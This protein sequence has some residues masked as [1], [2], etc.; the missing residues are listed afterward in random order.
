MKW[1]RSLSCSVSKT[2]KTTLNTSGALR[3]SLVVLV[4]VSPWRYWEAFCCDVGIVTWCN[5]FTTG[6]FNLISSCNQ[7]QTVNWKAQASSHDVLVRTK[8][9]S[10]GN[11]PWSTSPLPCPMPKRD[12]RYNRPSPCGKTIGLK[13]ICCLETE[14]IRVICI[15][16]F[17]ICWSMVVTRSRCC[18]YGVQLR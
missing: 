14:T 10:C 12:G 6:F 1:R 16:S 17:V 3:D 11:V 5:M 9:R 4:C 13:D 7:L 2:S 18:E 15:H 8:C